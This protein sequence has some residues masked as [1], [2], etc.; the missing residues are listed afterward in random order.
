[1]AQF[2]PSYQGVAAKPNKFC[3]GFG[4][5]QYDIQFFKNEDPD[6]FLE[7]RYTSFDASLKKALANFRVRPKKLVCIRSLHLPISKKLLWRSPT[8]PAASKPSLGLKQG[9]NLMTASSTASR[10]SVS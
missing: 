8:T 5:F 4:I 1:M 9:S 2:I 3:H 10:S 6:Y 7:R